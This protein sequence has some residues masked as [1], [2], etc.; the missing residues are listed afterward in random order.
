VTCRLALYGGSFDP[1]HRGHLHVARAAREQLD[2]ERVYLIPAGRPPHKSRRLSADRHREAMVRL[3]CEGREHVAVD[4]RELRRGGTSF[5]IDTV[6]EFCADHELADA[7]YFLIGS[8]SLA[9]LHTWHR[10]HELLDRVVFVTIPRTRADEGRGWDRL[11]EHFDADEV[12]RLTRHVLAVPALPVSSTQVRRAVSE[13]R[14]VT[15]LVPL[16]VAAYIER[17]D[18]YRS[19]GQGGKPQEARARTD[20]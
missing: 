3:L 17:H 18:L 19:A 11:G 8:D 14:D 1:P 7:P 6:A 4:P 5:T 9:E 15:S 13:R 2:L 12:A 20:S 16:A 10:I